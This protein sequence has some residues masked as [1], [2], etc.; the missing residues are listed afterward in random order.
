MSISNGSIVK[1]ISDVITVSFTGAVDIDIDIK[2]TVC[3]TEH[4]ER[5]QLVF[6]ESTDTI[7]GVDLLYISDVSTFVDAEG[8]SL[9]PSAD[10]LLDI[11]QYDIMCRVVNNSI[12]QV[13]L[14]TISDNIYIGQDIICSDFDVGTIGVLS[15][16]IEYLR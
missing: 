1:V 2:Y 11:T 5:V 16:I 12:A 4:Y 14:M 7:S 9:L 13:G 15:N 10:I 8:K 6:L 3:I